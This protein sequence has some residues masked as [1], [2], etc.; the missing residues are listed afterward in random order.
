LI[1]ILPIRG[2]AAEVMAVQM[3]QSEIP[4]AVASGMPADCPMLAGLGVAGDDRSDSK[5][6]HAVC[7]SC[8]LC[9]G[10]TA[11]SLPVLALGKSAPACLVVHNAAAFQSADLVRQQKPPIS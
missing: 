3:A 11:V 1:L 2:W 9:M 10:M 6:H 4:V 7:P 8:Q 5:N